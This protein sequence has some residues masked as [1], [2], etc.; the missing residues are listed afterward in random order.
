[1]CGGRFGG[2]SVDSIG[3]RGVVDVGEGL[4]ASTWP[5]LEYE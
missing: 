4:E 1:M 5:R 2:T 3:F